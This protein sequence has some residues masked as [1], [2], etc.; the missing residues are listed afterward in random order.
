MLSPGLA[1]FGMQSN[2]QTRFWPWVRPQRIG[3]EVRLWGAARCLGERSPL[4]SEG[5]SISQ[6]GRRLAS[7]HRCRSSPPT[8]VR[9]PGERRSITLA[10]GSS[11]DLNTRTSI[12]MRPSPNGAER[13]ELIAGEAS[14][15]TRP[16]MHRFVEVIAAVGRVVA[17]DADFNIRYESNVVCTTCISGKLDVMHEARVARVR[18][19]EQISYSAS[20]LGRLTKVDP[21]VV[22]AWKSGV[23]MF[24]S[25]PLTE[26]VAEIN[27]YRSAPIIVTSRA[28]G[29]RLFNARFQIASLDGVVEQIQQVFGVSATF[30]PGG[31]VLLS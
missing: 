6:L 23:L 21:S 15:A 12:A 24:Q 4:R 3:K 8:I 5:R 20:G 16:A 9:P 29:R 11:V 30:L 26:A 25:T 27:R 28:L 1:D 17:N 10:D 19:G 7:G 14:I 31:I 2:W 18:A 22:T 13:I